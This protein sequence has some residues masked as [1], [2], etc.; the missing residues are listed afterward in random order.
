MAKQRLRRQA[1]E[2]METGAAHDAEVLAGWTSDAAR[3][4]I[5]AA[6]AALAGRRSADG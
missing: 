6:M 5:E 2:V 1:V 3:R 4:S